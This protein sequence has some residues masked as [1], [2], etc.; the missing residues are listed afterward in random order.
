MTVLEKVSE[1]WRRA[2]GPSPPL[3]LGSGPDARQ[4]SLNFLYLP[5]IFNEPDAARLQAGQR[6]ASKVE[7]L[8][9][10]LQRA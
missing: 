2:F 1:P 7:Q 10:L 9:G 4:L 3:L 8:A 6:I 5:K